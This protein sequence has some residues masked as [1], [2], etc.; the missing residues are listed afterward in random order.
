MC[1]A[2]KSPKTQSRHVITIFVSARLLGNG[3]AGTPLAR[4][5]DATAD[6]SWFAAESCVGIGQGNA[7]AKREHDWHECES[8]PNDR[9][10]TQCI[11]LPAKMPRHHVHQNIVGTAVSGSQTGEDVSTSVGV[12]DGKRSVQCSM[13]VHCRA[14]RLGDRGV[15][16]TWPRLNQMRTYMKGVV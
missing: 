10:T 4:N 3:H 2:F 12:E 7:S 9:R 5:T 11:I 6:S 1:V 13:V 15:V 16:R 14:R 8:C